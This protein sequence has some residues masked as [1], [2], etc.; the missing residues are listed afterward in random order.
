VF[1]GKLRAFVNDPDHSQEPRMTLFRPA[2]SSAVLALLASGALAQPAAST[3]S[4]EPDDAKRLACY[5]RAVGRSAPGA[6]AAPAATTAPAPAPAEAAAPSILAQRLEAT[7]PNAVPGKWFSLTAHRTNYVLAYSYDSNANFEEYR[8]FGDIDKLKNGEIKYQLSLKTPLWPQIGDSSVSLWM[9]FTLQS[10][11][12]A[13]ASDVSA[14]FRETN[15]EPEIFAAM[16]VQGRLFGINFREVALGLNHQSN[17]R[18]DPLSR[19][20]NRVTSRVIFDS[21]NFAGYA[22]LWARIPE[23]EEDDDNPNIERYL[24][25]GEFALA[26][27]WGQHTF[28]GI[29]KN[30]MRSANR[31]GLQLDYTY[32]LNKHLKGYIQG[33]VGYG[34]SM[35]DAKQSTERIGVGLML[36]DWF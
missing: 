10:W 18:T 5:D 2:L 7:D 17:G 31:S 25:Q 36:A 4:N 19:S 12:Q 13:F 34:E 16:P 14:P 21:G 26:Y 28:A 1:A 35:I 27:R 33:Y 23:S 24:G 20:W 9:A 15:Y 8:Q 22:K 32:P 3:C 30:N 29:L 6:A 11:W